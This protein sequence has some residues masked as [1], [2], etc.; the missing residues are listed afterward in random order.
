MASSFPGA[1]LLWDFS[2]FG[3]VGCT[4]AGHSLP[5]SLPCQHLLLLLLIIACLPLRSVSSSPLSFRPHAC[6]ICSCEMLCFPA[7]LYW[8]LASYWSLYN[9]MGVSLEVE[10]KF[11][12]LEIRGESRNTRLLTALLTSF[13]DL[14]RVRISALFTTIKWRQLGLLCTV[15]CIN[16]EPQP[17]TYTLLSNL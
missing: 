4:P 12:T 3:H 11:E 9:S 13:I 15:F 8:F 10:G 16:P 14:T 5:A 1:T 17:G 6:E 2:P 7:Y